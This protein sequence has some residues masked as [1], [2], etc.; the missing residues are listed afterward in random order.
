VL[1]PLGEEEVVAPDERQL[2]FPPDDNQISRLA[3]IRL[4]GNDN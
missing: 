2:Y 3:V 1:R 4:P